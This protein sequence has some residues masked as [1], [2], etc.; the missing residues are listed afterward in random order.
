MALVVA[1][2]A[3]ATAALNAAVAG[4]GA[5]RWSR[6]EESPWFWR[7]VRAGQAAAALLAV[8]SGLGA[9]LGGAPEDRLFWLYVLL[10]LAV[11]L[12]AEQLRLVSAQTVLDAR[13]LEGAD[14][15]R[16]LPEREQHAIVLD[17]LRREM[18]VMAI[19]AGVIAFL[20][21]RAAA[22]TDGF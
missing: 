19:A 7:G 10:P 22:L 11:S 13:E 5:Y 12:V 3:L 17:I 18:G 4:L 6:A 21:L 16:A 20:A 15:M 8:A 2:L 9:A 1:L 14:A